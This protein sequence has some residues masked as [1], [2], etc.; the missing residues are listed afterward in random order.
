MGRP[1]QWVRFGGV[2]LAYGTAFALLR[3]GSRFSLDS[4]L[5]VIVVMVCFLGL[6]FV[7]APVIPI[8]MPRALKRIRPWE[9]E[10]SIYRALGVHAFGHLL[11]RTPLKQFNTDVYLGTGATGAGHLQAQLDVAEASH[12]WAAVLVLPYMIR[13]ALQGRWSAFFWVMAAQVLINLYPVMHLRL[14]RHRL[15]R[16]AMRRASEL[17]GSSEEAVRSARLLGAGTGNH[18]M[19]SSLPPPE[20]RP[21]PP[22][23]VDD[24]V[25]DGAFWRAFREIAGP[26]L[27]SLRGS[28]NAMSL[29]LSLVEARAPGAGEAGDTPARAARRQIGELSA[30]LTRVLGHV[31]GG[32]VLPDRCDV[33]AVADGACALVEPLAD[34]L[35]VL[36]ERRGSTEPVP[37]GIDAATVQAVLVSTLVDAVRRS[38]PRSAVSLC[39]EATQHDVVTIDVHV[40]AGS[41]PGSLPP[42]FL[43]ASARVLRRHGGELR[44]VAGESAACSI[45][46]RR[47][48][49]PSSGDTPPRRGDTEPRA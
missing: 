27:H 7:A 38:D 12:L 45:V 17:V 41:R 5:F 19:A 21:E 3:R 28:L 46:L 35:Q 22:A 43:E 11:R 23:E 40:D 20:R 18:H 2:V 37:A 16:V 49:G 48:T 39:I 14:A 31:S 13:A 1:A 29:N 36:I 30:G 47:A 10:G 8:G 33:A 44:C 9:A 4:P 15:N 32:E 25:I 26:W 34:H 24:L 6:T 42:G